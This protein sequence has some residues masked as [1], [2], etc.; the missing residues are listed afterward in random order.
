VLFRSIAD[1][2]ESVTILFADVVGFTE[3]SSTRSPVEIVNFLN[4]FFQ[5][6]DRLVDK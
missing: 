6:L 4:K 2:F 5:G 1:Y 3:Y